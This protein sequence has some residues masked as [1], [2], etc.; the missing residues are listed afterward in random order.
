MR[1]N[2][3]LIIDRD[4][5]TCKDIKY[6]VD[7]ATTEAYYTL[8]VRE[9][10]AELASKEYDLVILNVCFPEMDDMEVLK[11]LRGLKPMPILIL[12]TSS[13]LAEQLQAFKT[14][15]DDYLTK[16][17][18]TEECLAR[19][20]ALL[21]RFHELNPLKTR[22]Y[23]IVAHGDLMMKRDTR[24]ALISG[25]PLELTYREYELLNLF[26][27]HPE[28]VFTFEQ[29]YEQVWAEPY[30]GNK[31]SVVCE[32]KRLRKKLGD[33]DPIEAV[34]EVGYRFKKE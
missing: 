32:M 15:A 18:E 20:Y 19:V 12:S 23:S 30:M 8:T 24:Q 2:R 10:L 17:F 1:K 28:R 21:R 26:M 9:G 25:R 34:R 13:A 4:L 7:S 27:S 5:Q 29:L 14:G 31:N 16:P 11:T 6:N 3:V 33:T 22:A